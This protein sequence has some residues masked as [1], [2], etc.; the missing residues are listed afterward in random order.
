RRC[1]AAPP[2]DGPGQPGRDGA[3]DQQTGPHHST[4]EGRPGGGSRRAAPARRRARPPPPGPPPGAPGGRGRPRGADRRPGPCRFCQTLAM[5][6]FD[7]SLDKLQTYR[8][9]LPVPADLRSFWET[10]VAE[11]RSHDVAVRAERIDNRLRLVETFDV[12]Y[13]GFD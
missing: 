6:Q 11:A 7:F 10:T 4:H 3:G 5:A 12:T 13:A 9:D 1:V 8:P 2:A